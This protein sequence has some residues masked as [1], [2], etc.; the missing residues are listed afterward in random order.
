MFF[1]NLFLLLWT[2]FHQKFVTFLCEHVFAFALNTV[3]ILILIFNQYKP[4]KNLH[5]YLL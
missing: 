4:D 3:L 1:H 2:Y 5:K